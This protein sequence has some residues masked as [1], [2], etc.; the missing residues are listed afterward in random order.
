MIV[1]PEHGALKI[2]KFRPVRGPVKV[3][4]GEKLLECF[5]PIVTTCFKINGCINTALH[6]IVQIL[7]S[8]L[9]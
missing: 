9:H 7:G 6:N 3:V 4:D 2:A 8:M 1:I 5:R